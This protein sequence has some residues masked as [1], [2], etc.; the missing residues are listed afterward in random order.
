M[1]RFLRGD[2][3]RRRGGRVRLRNHWLVSGGVVVAGCG[4]CTGQAQRREHYELRENGGGTPLHDRP[5]VASAGH[6]ATKPTAT[7]RELTADQGR[8]AWP[9]MRRGIRR[10][11]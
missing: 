7:L 9:T 4:S 5:S 2:R 11:R 8:L 10:G 1:R 3:V 6:A